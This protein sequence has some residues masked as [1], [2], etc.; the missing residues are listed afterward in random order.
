MTNYWLNIT[1]EIKVFRVQSQAIKMKTWLIRIGL[2]IP[3]AMFI[4]YIMVIV[5]GIVMRTLL[6]NS[7]F[8]CSVY[9]KLAIL[10][11]VLSVFAV[12]CRES[13]ICWK[14]A[15]PKRK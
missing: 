1:M 6:A 9:C 10:L 4:T 3:L 7:E 5:I 12:V 11:F 8:Y 14:K 15:H 2:M 13:N